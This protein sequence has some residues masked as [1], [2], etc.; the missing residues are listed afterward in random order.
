V[1]ARKPDTAPRRPARIILVTFSPASLS[2]YGNHFGRLRGRRKCALAAQLAGV[3][4]RHLS[5]GAIGR[6][7]EWG[8]LSLA[9]RKSCHWSQTH[10]VLH[11]QAANCLAVQCGP[12]CSAPVWR[13]VLCGGLRGASLLSTTEACQSGGKAVRIVNLANVSPTSKFRDALGAPMATRK[14]GRH[15]LNC[16]LLAAAPRRPESPRD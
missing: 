4:A 10:A 12:A 5:C 2:D 1:A 8:P 6:H 13:Q 15:L 9:T 7:C 14:E 16:S 3:D 11:F